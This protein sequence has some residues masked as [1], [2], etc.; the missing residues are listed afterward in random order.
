MGKK[1]SIFLK[2]TGC[3]YSGQNII[4]LDGSYSV[5]QLYVKCWVQ[6]NKH[7]HLY[8]LSM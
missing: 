5:C 4:S 2:L 6:W 8:S 1:F 7:I 3:Q